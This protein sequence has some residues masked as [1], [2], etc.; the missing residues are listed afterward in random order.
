MILGSLI[1]RNQHSAR[2]RAGLIHE[3]TPG[4]LIIWHPQQNNNLA[5]ELFLGVGGGRP[6]QIA[7]NFQRNSSA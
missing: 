5:G 4:T 2:N 3:G 6:A 1:D 7:D